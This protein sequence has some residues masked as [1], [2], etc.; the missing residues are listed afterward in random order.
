MGRRVEVVDPNELGERGGHAVGEEGQTD[1]DDPDLEEVLHPLHAHVQT[2]PHLVRGCSADGKPV[3]ERQSDSKEPAGYEIAVDA[4]S[5]HPGEEPA[6]VS[7]DRPDPSTETRDGCDVGGEEPQVLA[8]DLLEVAFGHLLVVFLDFFD[9]S[10]I[11]GVDLVGLGPGFGL[12]RRVF[13]ASG[14][15]QKQQNEQPPVHLNY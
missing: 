8:S 11:I 3:E 2:A 5:A 12:G 13:Q 1:Q 4:A 6:D 14:R 15:Q 10:S 7:D 9:L